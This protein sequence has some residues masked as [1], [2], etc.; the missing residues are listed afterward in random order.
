VNNRKSQI[1]TEAE[2]EEGADVKVGVAE[3]KM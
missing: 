1:P 3:E 2:S